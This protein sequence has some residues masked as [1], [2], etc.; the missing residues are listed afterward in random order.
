M[1]QRRLAKLLLRPSIFSSTLTILLAIAILGI[2]IW[3][4]T[5]NNLILSQYIYGPY[6]IVTVMEKSSDIANFTAAFS[7]S[8]LTYNLL[9]LGVAILIAAG[10][11]AILQ[12]ISKIIVGSYDTWHAIHDAGSSVQSV[13]REIG[14]RLTVRLLSLSLWIA[15]IFF[16]MGLV[17]PYCIFITRDGIDHLLHLDW[18]VLNGL[19]GFT[20]LAVSLHFHVIFMRL[21]VLRPRVF[22]GKL[23]ILEA[24]YEADNHKD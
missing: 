6:G 24:I 5:A 12:S 21:I 4:Y 2:S 8:P 20:I 14:A 19:V 3:P 9:I 16:F 11:Y 10:V 13:E 1:H 18:K 17:L 23:D 15:F 7:V 22:G